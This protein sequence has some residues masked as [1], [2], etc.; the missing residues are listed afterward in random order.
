M[1]SE[2]TLGQIVKKSSNSVLIEHWKKL[3]HVVPSQSKLKKYGKCA[4]SIDPAQD[5]CTLR[6][7]KN[8]ILGALPKSALELSSKMTK[9]KKNLWQGVQNQ[10]QSNHEIPFSKTAPNETKDL[11]MGAAW[12]QVD[13]NETKL[14]EQ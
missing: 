13:E 3:D 14:L 12:D 10:Q 6:L 1:N 2:H 9:I 5:S 7:S 4:L 11:A 8:K